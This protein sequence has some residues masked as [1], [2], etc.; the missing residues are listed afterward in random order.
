MS[1]YV[2]NKPLARVAFALTPNRSTTG[3][4]E[5]PPHPLAAIRQIA[6]IPLRQSWLHKQIGVY[7]YYVAI[8]RSMTVSAHSK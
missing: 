1:R 5:D 6:G 7:P 2:S 8:K 3:E 4:P